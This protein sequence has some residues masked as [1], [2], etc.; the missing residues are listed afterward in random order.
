LHTGCRLCSLTALVRWQKGTLP[1]PPPQP[2]PP[3]LLHQPPPPPIVGFPCEDDNL[4]IRN[5]LWAPAGSVLLKCWV[6][7]FKE[8]SLFCLAFL[9]NL[10]FCTKNTSLVGYKRKTRLIDPLC[11]SIC[12]CLSMVE[13]HRYV[14]LDHVGTNKY[15]QDSGDEREGLERERLESKGLER[16]FSV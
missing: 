9:F 12:L 1:P 8:T 6:S 5:P 7:T 2:P 15:R 4:G 11:L 3:P 14:L 10:P 13:E 16:F